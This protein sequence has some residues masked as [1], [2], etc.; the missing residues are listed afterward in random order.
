MSIEPQSIIHQVMRLEKR[1]LHAVSSITRRK[2]R[3]SR[4]KDDEIDLVSTPEKHVVSDEFTDFTEATQLDSTIFSLQGS[5]QHSKEGSG[6]SFCRTLDQSTFLSDLMI[7]PV[8]SEVT[9]V[10]FFMN[11]SEISQD[12]DM[13]LER[14]EGIHPLCRFARIDSSMAPYITRRLN[15]Q[16]DKP[17]VVALKN[18]KLVNRISDFTEDCSELENWVYAIELMRMYQ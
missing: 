7:T 15:I 16:S 12:I 5:S 13:Q 10:H 1:F 2:T 8:S 18:G 17:T 9:F 11:D 3:R 14:L 6:A 4:T